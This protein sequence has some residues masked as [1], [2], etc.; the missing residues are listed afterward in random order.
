LFLKSDG[1]EIHPGMQ[2]ET[3]QHI[4]DPISPIELLQIAPED[5]LKHDI[6]TYNPQNA[7]KKP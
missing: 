6:E 3:A 2:T 5:T 1:G 7:A 4:D